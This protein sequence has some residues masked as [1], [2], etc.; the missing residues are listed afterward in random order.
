MEGSVYQM[1]LRR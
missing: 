1:I